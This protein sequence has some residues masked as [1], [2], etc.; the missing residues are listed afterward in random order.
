MFCFIFLAIMV[1][2][3]HDIICQKLLFVEIHF[4]ALSI[5]YT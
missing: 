4:N 2:D 3:Y 5:N 1:E